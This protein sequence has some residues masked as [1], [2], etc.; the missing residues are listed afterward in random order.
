MVHNGI[1]YGLMQL[2][3]ETYDLMKRGLNFN[4]DQL[5]DVFKKWNDGELQS[6]LVE[7]TADI[8]RQPD[9]KTGKRLVDIILDQAK[10]KGTGKWTTE[11]AMELQV[12]I[13]TIDIAVSMRDMSTC[14]SERESAA[15]RLTGPSCEY[16][17]G[18]QAFVAQLSNA[19][20]A[21]MIAT[22]AQGL[23]LLRKASEAYDYGLK[24][25]DVA[26]IWR[27]GCI[28]RAGL[29]EDVR[30]AYESDPDLPNL[31]V[32]PRLSSEFLRRQ[33]DLRAVVKVG[34]E[35]GIP[36]PAL[37]ATLAYFD[38]YRSAWLPA[39]L[40][41]AQRD[42]FGAHTYER[43]DEKGVFHTQWDNE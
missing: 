22:Y 17:G 13:P 19:F 8:F 16:P 42:F 14:K 33:N 24:L 20:Y 10:Q 5:H 18:K 2:I 7:I 12:P 27:G 28:I 37:M 34:I 43:I 23:S 31:M 30:A 26:R 4:D 9:P 41:Q 36:V 35:L 39:N 21:A 38:S 40:I 6:Y 15:R 29:L 1:E 3:S 25:G 11:D 32:D